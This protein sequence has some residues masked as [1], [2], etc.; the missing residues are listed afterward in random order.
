MEKVWGMIEKVKME[1]LALRDE[2]V[3][4]KT[5]STRLL[6]DNVRLQQIMDKVVKQKE[7]AARLLATG[8]VKQ[9]NSAVIE[10]L[11]EDVLSA[12]VKA[13]KYRYSNGVMRAGPK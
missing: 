11:M 5:A 9:E 12:T 7:A 13:K 1:S 6:L 2:L 4:K 3:A 8:Q 10:Q